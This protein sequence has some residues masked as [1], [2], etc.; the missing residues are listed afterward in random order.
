ML[1]AAGIYALQHNIDRLKDDHENARILAQAIRETE[2]LNLIYD[3]VET[4]MVYFT[5]ENKSITAQ[6]IVDK[7]KEKNIQVNPVNKN[8]IRMVTNLGV[9]RFDIMKVCQELK[10]I[11]TSIH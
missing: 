5:F 1:A 4:N 10:I 2:G 11:L 3:A 7:L 9:K 8:T 6:K